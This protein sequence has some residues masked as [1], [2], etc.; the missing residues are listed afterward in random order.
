MT[1]FKNIPLIKPQNNLDI[2]NAIIFLHGYG[3]NGKDL[4]NIGHEWKEKHPHT[5]FISPNAPFNC[6]WGGDA[7]QWFDLTSIAPEKIGEGLEKAGP[8]LNKL[9]EDVKLKFSLKDNEIIFFGFS[10]G[11]MMGLYH[12]CKRENK[13]AGLLAYS[14]LLYENKDFD[15]QVKAKFPIRIFHGRDDEVVDH[16]YSLKSYEKLKSLGFDV[17]IKIQDYLGHGINHEG[18]SFGLN[19]VR[20]IFNI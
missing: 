2:K 13:C 8:I 1:D 15:G 19:F 3:A 20:E 10:Q 12:L 14:G 7:Y 9:I 17:E 18:L 4:I 6:D 16:Q 11:A 5:V